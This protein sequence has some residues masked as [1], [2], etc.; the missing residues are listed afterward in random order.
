MFSWLRVDSW[1]IQNQEIF[2]EKKKK[3]GSKG[4]QS[5]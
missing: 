4:L 2:K 5:L 3:I 1:N